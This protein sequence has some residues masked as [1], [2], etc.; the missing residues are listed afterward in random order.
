MSNVTNGAIAKASHCKKIH[1][2][3]VVI[4]LLVLLVA[5]FTISANTGTIRLSPMELFRTCS[6]KGLH[7]RN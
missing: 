7:S 1:D 4:I 5:A 6:D 2:W 3:I